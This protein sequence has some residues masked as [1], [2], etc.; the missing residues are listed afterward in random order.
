MNSNNL[1][2]Q[3]LFSDGNN[4]PSTSAFNNVDFPELIVAT[5]ANLGIFIFHAQKHTHYKNKL[6][7]HNICLPR[8]FSQVYNFL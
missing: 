8:N 1:D 3:A 7:P 5:I 2:V 6:N 4:A